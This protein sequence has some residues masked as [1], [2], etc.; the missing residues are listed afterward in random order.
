MTGQVDSG[1]LD[2]FLSPARRIVSSCSSYSPSSLFP[3]RMG[4][5]TVFAFP[6][7]LSTPS[8]LDSTPTNGRHFTLQPNLSAATRLTLYI[9]IGTT[10]NSKTSRVQFASGITLH[11]SLADCFTSLMFMFH[12]QFE[13]LLANGIDLHLYGICDTVQANRDIWYASQQRDKRGGFQFPLIISAL[14]PQHTNSSLNPSCDPMCEQKSSSDAKASL[15][16]AAFSHRSRSSR[17]DIP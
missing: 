4:C 12:V 8:S 16:T 7:T 2:Q 6:A 13:V 11:A 10:F 3:G 15:Q 5:D 14:A 9:T 1:A 17:S